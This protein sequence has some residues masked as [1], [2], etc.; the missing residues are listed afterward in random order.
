MGL[1]AA[2]DRFA[3]AAA[4]GGFG[5]EGVR[6]DVD[7]GRRAERRWMDDLRRDVFSVSKTV[8]S[9]AIGMIEDD[10]LLTMNDPVLMHLPELADTAAPGSEAITVGHLLRMTAGNE[11]FGRACGPSDRMSP[12]SADAMES[13]GSP[14][15]GVERPSVTMVVV[16]SPP[17]EFSGPEP[18]DLPDRS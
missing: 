11:S 14:P 13:R 1:E 6:V 3:D 5:I 12:W 2:L 15:G 17:R 10:A 4:D 16:N 9:L 8:P 7:D 18:G